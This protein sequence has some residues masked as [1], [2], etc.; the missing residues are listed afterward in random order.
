MD[1][2][3]AIWK[4]KIVAIQSPTIEVR[5]KTLDNVTA[6]WESIKPIVMFQHELLTIKRFL[7]QIHGSCEIR[8]NFVGSLQGHYESAMYG[9]Y[10]NL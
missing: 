6:A 8:W 10:D 3:E 9:G 4:A 7:A 1:Y 5:V 2:N